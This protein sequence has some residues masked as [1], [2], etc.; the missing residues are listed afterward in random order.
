MRRSSRPLLLLVLIA[1]GLPL[2]IGLGAVVTWV[3]Q[4]FG[5]PP[6]TPVV[7]LLLGTLAELIWLSTRRLRPWAINRQVPQSWG[8]EHGPWK[9][10]LRYG[11]RLG[12]GPATILT[13][14]S[15]WAGLLVGASLGVAGSFVFALGFVVFRN[16]V[17]VL[18]PGNPTD[19]SV[20]AQRMSRLRAFDRVGSFVGVGVMCFA[21][22]LVAFDTWG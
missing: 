6:T 17:T 19:G 5:F 11:P 13:S 15:W 20:I 10:A 8:H 7:F 12:L 16:T 1:S 14:W 22:V 2:A 4:S 3:V 18:L 9:A 21:L